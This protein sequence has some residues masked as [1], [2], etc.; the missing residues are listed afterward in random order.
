MSDD[1]PVAHSPL[2]CEVTR[3]GI[4]V[5]ICIYRGPEDPG[6]LLEVVDEEGGST[7]WEDHLASDQE[8]L[9]LAM[10]TIE[11]EGIETFSKGMSDGGHE[12]RGAHPRRVAF[13]EPLPLGDDERTELEASLG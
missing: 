10:K 5:E 12:S 11:E 3:D 8:A 2:E 1:Y 7:I 9:D 6:W 4:T 13:M